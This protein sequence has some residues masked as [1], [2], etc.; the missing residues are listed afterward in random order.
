MHAQGKKFSTTT[1]FNLYF[2]LAGVRYILIYNDDYLADVLENISFVHV[3]SY[4]HV[5]E[6]TRFSNPCWLSQ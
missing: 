4:I 2:A 6:I 5:F 1:K 3:F